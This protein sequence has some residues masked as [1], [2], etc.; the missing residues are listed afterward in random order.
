M[1]RDATWKNHEEA[2]F[3]DTVLH[4]DPCWFLGMRGTRIRSGQGS[5]A[6]VASFEADTVGCRFRQNTRW[7]VDLATCGTSAWLRGH[8]VERHRS[9]SFAVE[10][11]TEGR[12]ELRVRQRRYEL[13]PGDVFILH[14]SEHHRYCSTSVEVFRKMFAMVHWTTQANRD[15]LS[16]LGLMALSHVRPSRAR[17]ARIREVFENLCAMTQTDDAGTH[18]RASALTY[19]LLLLVSESVAHEKDGAELPLPVSRALRWALRG[20]TPNPSVSQLARAAGCSVEHLN[21]LFNRHLGTRTHEWLTRRKL[22]TAVEW[23]LYSGMKIHEISSK[24]G[25]ED[26]CCFSR[27]FHRYTGLAPSECR[28]R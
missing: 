5:G 1:P 2:T 4:P 26:S 19:N 8:S 11:V 3:D 21:R 27:A 22:C 18:E 14:P 20:E 25:Y 6:E 7:P 23:L 12:G 10:F 9:D 28:R 15:A 13:Q 24:L 17:V 16:T